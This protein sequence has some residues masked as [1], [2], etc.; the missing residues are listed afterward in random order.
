MRAAEQL[1]FARDIG[2]RGVD[3]RVVCPP[4][5]LDCK[6]ADLQQVE[7]P[8]VVDGE[9]HVDASSHAKGFELGNKSD[10]RR[11]RRWAG[12]GPRFEAEKGLE[13]VARAG[14]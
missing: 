4:L 14:R 5:A 3:L 13:I 12:I 9:L 2:E 8:V 11:E 1:D 7:L 10:D 6:P